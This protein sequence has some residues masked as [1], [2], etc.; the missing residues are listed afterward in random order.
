MDAEIFKLKENNGMVMNARPKYMDLEKRKEI[1]HRLGV[2]FS[3]IFGRPDRND[4][5]SDAII[6]DVANSLCDLIEAF[7]NINV[8]PDYFWRVIMQMNVVLKKVVADKKKNELTIRERDIME[9]H[10]RYLYDKIRTGISLKDRAHPIDINDNYVE[11]LSFYSV[12]GL[13]CNKKELLHSK[14]FLQG[15]GLKCIE[16]N[17]DLL[18]TD[19]LVDD[20]KCMMDML[21]EYMSFFVS[22][23]VNPKEYV[24]KI[25]AE[26]ENIQNHQK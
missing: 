3:D 15:F 21:F 16:Y 19:D 1:V 13:P 7:A 8:Y 2:N 9:S 26:R 25:M 5:D 12:F 20:V 4:Y 11:L 22:V 24:D 17:Y 23:G 6:K 14:S 18:N 10:D